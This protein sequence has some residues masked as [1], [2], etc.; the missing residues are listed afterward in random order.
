ME[1]EAG[2]GG[3][4]ARKSASPRRQFRRERGRG[5]LAERERL[6]FNT[7]SYEPEPKRAIAELKELRALTGR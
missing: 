7:Y 1:I 3:D 5:K 4:S 2:V 6:I